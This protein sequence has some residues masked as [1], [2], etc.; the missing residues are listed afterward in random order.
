[1]IFLRILL[2][3]L[4]VFVTFIFGLLICLWYVGRM[5]IV[6]LCTILFGAVSGKSAEDF[7]NQCCA[8]ER[9]TK[10]ASLFYLFYQAGYRCTQ[11]AEFGKSFE[12]AINSKPEVERILRLIDTDLLINV[13]ENDIHG[14]QG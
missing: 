1:M 14:D 5:A 10:I 9:G 12:I 4:L 13:T 11:N 6:P 7:C 8:T 2:L 3:A